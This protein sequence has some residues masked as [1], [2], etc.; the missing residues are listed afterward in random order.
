[1]CYFICFQTHFILYVG[2]PIRLVDGSSEKEGRVEIFRNRQ[3]STICDNGWDDNDAVVVCKQ[4]GFS[5]G[6][7]RGRA[8]FGKGTGVILLNNVNCTGNERSIYACEHNFDVHG[9]KHRRDAGVICSGEVSRGML[10]TNLAGLIYL[11]TFALL[12]ISS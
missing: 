12:H 6:S 10:L 11:V 4:L 1:M 8:Y 7:A 2:D 3:W 9:C 5:G